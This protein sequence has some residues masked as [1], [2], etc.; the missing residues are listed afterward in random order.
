MEFFIANKA[1]VLGVLLAVSELLS[2]MPMFKSNGIAQLVFN[3]VKQLVA[4]APKA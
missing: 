2:V 1:L 4:P 3:F